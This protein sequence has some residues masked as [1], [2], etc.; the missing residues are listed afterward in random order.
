[1]DVNLICSKNF[2]KVIIEILSAR[3]FKVSDDSS[4]SIIER[5]YELPDN[6]I[7][8]LFDHKTLDQLIVLLDKL[9]EGSDI[10]KNFVLGKLEE[11]YEVIPFVDILY[12]QSSGNEISLRTA[13]SFYKVKEKLYELEKGLSGNGFVR[14]N[15]ANLVNILNV[16]YISPWFGGK[17]LL[18][19][20]D[21]N[22]QVEVTKNYVKDFKDYLGM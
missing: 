19:F 17:L 12:F 13:K 7:G 9:S 11:K 20:K 3:G 6:K 16:K 18:N 2:Y 4:Y 10:L 8:I 1:M 15:K 21:I 5:N 22:D 14:I